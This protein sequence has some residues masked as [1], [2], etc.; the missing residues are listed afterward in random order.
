MRERS[1]AVF[2][3]NKL[4]RQ[5]RWETWDSTNPWPELCLGITQ[6][7]LPNQHGVC[8]HGTPAMAL[9]A[10]P[11]RDFSH[12]CIRVEDPV[13]LAR[14]LQDQQECIAD[15]IRT[16]TLAAKTLR[17]DLKRP[18]PVPIVYGTHSLWKMV[19]FTSF[20]ISFA[21]TKLWSRLSSTISTLKNKSSRPRHSESGRL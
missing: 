12:G 17:V 2:S 5:L 16:A 19:M 1:W 14:L 20:G 11:R 3:A 7:R 18:V 6:V 13:A 10:R 15:H 4:K 9:L 8:M 21:K